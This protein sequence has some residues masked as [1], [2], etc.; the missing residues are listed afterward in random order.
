VQNVFLK[1]DTDEMLKDFDNRIFFT[2]NLS[3]LSVDKIMDICYYSLWRIAG[4]SYLTDTIIKSV[5][6]QIINVMEKW[7]MSQ[8][9]THPTVSFFIDIFSPKDFNSTH[10]RSIISDWLQLCR[11]NNTN[12]VGAKLHK[13]LLDQ[14]SNKEFSI[15]N[16]LDLSVQNGLAGLGLSL[17]SE[18]DGDNSWLLLFPNDL[19]PSKK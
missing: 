12:N 5:I 14:F 1:A 4:N 16:D 8:N 18:L 13:H 17:I 3:Y 15:H 7:Q 2:F 10:N 19:I 6:P 11:K 9:I